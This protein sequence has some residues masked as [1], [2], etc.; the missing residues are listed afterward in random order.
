[1][2]VEIKSLSGAT[3]HKY[4]PTLE[5]VFTGYAFR[6]AV[7]DAAN[8]GTSLRGADLSGKNLCGLCLKNVD[9]CGASFSNSNLSGAS[10]DGVNF[11]EA[12]FS[13]ARMY[14]TRFKDS[15]FHFAKFDNAQ[16]DERVQE[17]NFVVGYE[18]DPH[19]GCFADGAA[20][21]NGTSRMMVDLSQK[22][23]PERCA[24]ILESASQM[25]GRKLAA[26]NI[27]H[28]VWLSDDSGD[29]EQDCARSWWIKPGTT[30]RTVTLWFFRTLGNQFTS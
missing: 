7:E 17:M 21:R 11:Q 25:S 6:C 13:G 8:K 22:I 24:K 5:E 2:P 3:L 18:W 28:T 4:E 20:V 27:I 19:L 26:I 30:T 15:R 9:F 29:A 10:F 1:M 23:T 14:A 12:D 16:F